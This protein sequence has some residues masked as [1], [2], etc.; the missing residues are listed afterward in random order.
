METST[1]AQQSREGTGPGGGFWTSLPGVLTGLATLATA[2]LGP[3]FAYSHFAGG[4]DSTPSKPTPAAA[5]ASARVPAS[6]APAPAA[7]PTSA[8]APAPTPAAPPAPAAPAPTRAAPAPTQPLGHAAAPPPSAQSVSVS[9]LRT[10][11]LSQGSTQAVDAGDVL[12]GCLQGDD[13]SCAD[14]LDDLAGQCDEGQFSACDTLYDVSPSGSDWEAFGA[15]CG[16]RLDTDEYADL[17]GAL[18]GED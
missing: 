16:G 1:K 15:T 17:C 8:P 10:A 5:S 6:T 12:D 7:P 13:G 4:G 11:G 18:A 14:Y 9:S 2:I 3:I